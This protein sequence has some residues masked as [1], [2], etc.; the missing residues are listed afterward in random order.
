MGLNLVV[1]CKTCKIQAFIYRGKGV[2][3]ENFYYDHW[4]CVR[5]DRECMVL[6]DD[7]TSAPWVDASGWKCI[8]LPPYEDVNY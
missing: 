4:S 8:E 5:K 7:Q 3:I 1:G 2:E 6:S